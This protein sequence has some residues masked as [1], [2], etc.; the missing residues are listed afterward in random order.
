MSKLAAGFVSFC[1]LVIAV[2]IGAVM[3]RQ[4]GFSLAEAIAIA[5]TAAVVLVVIQF[6]VLRRRDNAYLLNRIEDLSD[7]VEDFLDEITTFRVRLEEAEKVVAEKAHAEVSKR[8]KLH[9]DPLMSEHEM[10]GELVKQMADAVS[11]IDERMENVEET[12]KQAMALAEQAEVA[13]LTP[14]STVSSLQTATPNQLSAP[15]RP[16]AIP[17]A[18]APVQAS[19][20]EAAVE[21]QPSFVPQGPPLRLTSAQV[22][23]HIKSG[24]VT[25][26]LQ[27]IVTLPDRKIVFYE[28]LARLTS[29][30][31]TF[32]PADFLAP[33]IQGGIIPAIDNLIVYRAVNVVRRLQER[34]PEMGMFCNLSPASLSDP[35][36]FEVLLMYLDENKDLSEHVFFEFT[37]ADFENF[38]PIEDSNLAQIVGAGFKISLDQVVNLRA[39]FR[40]YSREG[41]RFLKVPAETLIQNFERPQSDIHPADLAALLR[42]YSIDLIVDRMET[43]DQNVRLLEVASSYGQG[44]LFSRPKPVRIEPAEAR[45]GVIDVRR[46]AAAQ[47]A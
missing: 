46:R 44:F 8:A 41:I 33:A 2:S 23:E 29:E 15:S 10:L 14:T 7:Q 37:Q 35:Q 4:L 1:I 16:V 17:Q 36:F 31:E 47:S 18:I 38:G 12:A 39:D 20:T 11:G 19:A 28:A 24:H 34:A 30:T 13:A 42:R 21:E 45:R 5:M 25:M 27:P 40:R 22:R 9:V 43:E 32:L 26:M 6:H 3:N